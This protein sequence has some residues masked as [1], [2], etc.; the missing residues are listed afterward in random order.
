MY[1]PL[2]SP[3]NYLLLWRVGLTSHRN[4]VSLC[5]VAQNLLLPVACGDA[6]I[7][8]YLAVSLFVNDLSMAVLI[9]LLIL[10]ESLI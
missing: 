3:S 7:K 8:A 2:H 6:G 10:N 9:Y 5:L 1:F 4:A